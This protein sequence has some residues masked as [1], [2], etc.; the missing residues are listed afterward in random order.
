MK[1]TN[2]LT[3][4][5]REWIR[6]MSSQIYSGSPSGKARARRAMLAFMHG[7]E[8]RYCGLPVDNLYDMSHFEFDHIWDIY[9]YPVSPVTGITQFRISGS[10][11]GNRAWDRV[12]EHGLRDCQLLCRDCHIATTSWRRIP[13]IRKYGVLGLRPVSR[14]L[15]VAQM[16]LR[17]HTESEE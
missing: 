11:C 4:D 14:A 6:G 1:S 12:K 9:K 5:E 13:F 15:A 7:A 10:D 3:E 8:C 17:Q 2:T 16:G